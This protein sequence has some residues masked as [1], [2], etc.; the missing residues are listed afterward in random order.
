MDFSL[1]CDKKGIWP[2]LLSGIERV[3]VPAR[4]G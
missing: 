3:R 1:A 4:L 2:P